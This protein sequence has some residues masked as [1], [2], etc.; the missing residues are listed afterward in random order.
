MYYFI[1]NN[2]GKTL[3][4]I[5]K[6]QLNR[7]KLFTKHK[8]E[9]QCVFVNLNVNLYENA[10]SFGV[11]SGIYTIYDYF[12]KSIDYSENHF[13]WLN[14]WK[15]TCQ[16]DIKFIDKTTDVRI[17]SNVEYIMYA[18]FFDADYSKLSYI[19]YFDNNGRKFKRE[20]FDSRGFLSIV[21]Y[22]TANQKILFEHIL[23]IDGNTVI[24][25]HYNT[26]VD[27]QTLSRLIL[28]ESD[29]KYHLKSNDDLLT[30]FTNR[31]YK[32]GDVFFS[33][34]NNVTAQGLINSNVDIPLIAVLHSTHLKY[35]HEPDLKNIK[36]TYRNLFDNLG[37]FSGLI[38]STVQQNK[39]VATLID[40]S[41]PVWNIPV[42]Y[43]AEQANIVNTPGKVPKLISVARLSVEKQLDHQ[44]RLVKRLKK[45]IENVEL[46]MFGS[47]PEL[48]KL[49]QLIKEYNIEDNVFLRGFVTNL[50]EELQQA[51]VNLLTSRMEGFSLALLEASSFGL[52]SVSYDIEYGPAEIIQDGQSGYLVP[53]DDEDMLYDRVKELLLCSDKQQQFSKETLK[54]AE[55]YSEAE[56][57]SIWKRVLDETK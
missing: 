51:H 40:D 12:Q 47:G 9:A 25:K 57:V 41:L 55:R 20:I 23:D 34:K 4:G 36:N 26:E 42:G 44:L 38:A 45:D 6:A 22:L 37:R 48:G 7:L 46:H 14:Y 52:P 49:K 8:I 18:H 15:H 30:I 35:K 53:L 39:D 2:L 33:D 3:T 11:T 10:K 50:D 32:E 13:D 5:E 17:Y 43:I 1:G 31:I 27:K 19:N 24:E 56:L 28:N 16:Y 54:T 29:R 21:K